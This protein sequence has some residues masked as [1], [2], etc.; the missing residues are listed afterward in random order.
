MKIAVL[1][2]SAN[3]KLF[4]TIKNRGHQ[5]ILMNPS[6]CYMFLTENDKAN[7]RL[8]YGEDGKEPKR[9][10]AGTIDAVIPRI[11]SNL[12][13]SVSLLRFLNENL[14][15]YT[16][17]NPWGIL[18][19]ANKSMTLQRLASVGIRIPRTVIAD[20]PVHAA[21]M[22]KMVGSL[23][24]IIKT[25]HGSQG[26]TVA[27]ADTERTAN[28][29]LEFAMNA[30]LK[31]LVEEFLPG[32]AVDYRC[33]VVGDQVPLIMKRSSTDGDFRANLSRGGKG[34]P[35][36]LSKADKD[37][38]VKAAKA[39]GMGVAGVD[40]MISKKT[41]KSYILEVNSNSGVRALDVCQYN[42]WDDVV[43]FI[44]SN[45]KADNTAGI[46]AS[47]TEMALF[48]QGGILK[49]YVD[50][51]IRNGFLMEELD[52]LTKDKRQ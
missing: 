45:Y 13:Y 39:L 35:A 52:K 15:I 8:Y 40:L 29:V 25:N 49:K 48:N 27:I 18:L 5:A 47:L 10:Q 32:D 17:N 1:G 11:G 16:V 23:P 20:T 2:Y 7:D 6:K 37:L 51:S 3:K 42:V 46:T 14:N 44:E 19:A 21:W 50:L 36:D 26:K 33:W 43:S 31:I 12:D 30:G 38:C 24:V 4:D 41:G 34:E 28:S 9:V 22:V